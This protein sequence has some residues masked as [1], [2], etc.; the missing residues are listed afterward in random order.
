MYDC[1][2]IGGGPAGISTAIYL[3]RKK[4]NI[5]I[6]TAD[7]GGQ[8]AKA[9]SVENYLGFPKISGPE[10]TAKFKEHLDSL[11]IEN[12]IGKVESLN[13]I[14]KGFEIKTD[15][16]T[17]QTRSVIVA[18]VK[19][20]RKLGV[21]GEKEFEGKGVSYCAICDGPLFKDK[22]VAVIGGGNSALDAAIEIEKYA[23]KVYIVNISQEIQGDEVLREKFSKSE[24]TQAFN[25]VKTT[26]IFGEQF[27]KGLKYEDQESKEI[28]ELVCDGI[29][30][31]IGWTPSTDF[32]KGIVKLNN[33]KE[34][35]LDKNN[36]TSVPGIFA[37]G[38][39]TNVLNKQIVIAA[40][41]GANT[42]LST[43]KYLITQR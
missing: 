28:K 25:N 15:T 19:M 21:P 32:L 26:E 33:L 39:V 23:K 29:F 1:L 10:L 18:S 37:A 3:A 4:M 9:S 2:I 31:E 43:W 27:V 22:T 35:E 7:F 17:I 24:K 14:D 36:Q 13:K 40:G 34:I 42:A 16:N 5:V 38:D 12:K 30:I 8:A 11:K 6:L 41:E 20:P